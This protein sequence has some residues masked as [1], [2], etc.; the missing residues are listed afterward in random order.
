MLDNLRRSL[1][2]AA[3]VAALVGWAGCCRSRGRALW[4]ALLVLAVLRSPRSCGAF[5]RLVARDAR[6]LQRSFIERTCWPTSDSVAARARALGPAG[7]QA[8]ADGATRSCR[9]SAAL[10]VSRRHLLEWTTAA[11]GRAAGATRPA[12]PLPRAWGGWSLAVGRGCRCRADGGPRRRRWRRPSAVVWAASPV[13]ALGEPAARAVADA[14]R[15]RA[16]DRATLRDVARDTWR[17]FERFVDRR[18]PPPAARQ[19]AGRRR[20]GRRATAPRRPTSAS[21]CSRRRA[22]ATSA[23]SA[24]LEMI[25]RLEATLATL[26]RL[27]ALPRPPPQLVRHAR[28]CGR[29]P[30]TSPRRQRQPR[31]HLLALAQAC[32]EWAD[33]AGDAAARLAGRLDRTALR[34]H[35]PRAWRTASTD[36]LG[37]RPRLERSHRAPSAA[38]SR[39]RRRRRETAEALRDLAAPF[40]ELPHSAGRRCSRDGES[41][42]SIDAARWVGAVCGDPASRAMTAERDGAASAVAACAAARCDARATRLA[43]WRRAMDF[44]F[45]LRPRAPAALHRLPRRAS[46]GSTRAATTCS[47]PRRARQLVAIAKGDVPPRHWFRL[48]PA[49][50][51]VGARRG[52]ACRGRARCSST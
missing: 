16:D 37:R 52:A 7:Q 12:R 35:A 36:E 51:A 27:R 34:S 23:G 5:G 32:L 44:G 38:A 28:R 4:A 40:D 9:R 33:A 29:C 46:T 20:A 43:R 6:H 10:F 42:T 14:P 50:D 18:G 22:R 13:V 1:V 26:R 2:A 30:P 3:C 31:G 24:P 8:L 39:C 15:S 25:E 49:A 17:L 47:P 21:T 19:P 11:A 48:G 41:H 45:L